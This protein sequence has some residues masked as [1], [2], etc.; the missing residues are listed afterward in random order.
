MKKNAGFTLIE[1]SIVILALAIVT[2]GALRY[3][4][5]I[6]TSNSNKAVNTTLDVVEAALQNYRNVYGRLPCPADI[7][8]A[9]SNASF[10]TEI[11]T[12]ADGLCTGA[13]FTNTTTDPDNADP[14]YD[15]TTLSQ[16]TA[17]AIPVK[18]LKLPNRFAY[19][20]YGRKILYAVDKRIT[21]YGAFLQY[22]V[23]VTSGAIVVK[24]VATNA[25]SNALTYNAL[26][27]LVSYGKN[28]HGGYIRNLNN[29]STRFN[30]SSTNSD[31]LKNC[32]CDSTAT[33][34]NFDRIFVQKPVTGNAASGLQF[35][36]IVR[37]KTR[38]QLQTLAETQ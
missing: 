31:E 5:A 3:A 1:L 35:D 11:E 18:A 24:V 21:A 25:L 14:L 19:D 23:Q 10:G 36:D 30:A 13:N 15:A 8:L 37:F 20:A 16:V 32:H 7:T 34:T 33:A 26:Y 6:S 17:G 2:V 27:S 28:G 9:E 4:T 38:S 12:L 22:P 29:T